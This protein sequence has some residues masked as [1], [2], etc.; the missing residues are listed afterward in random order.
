M[1]KPPSSDDYVLQTKTLLG[2]AYYTDISRCNHCNV[3]LREEASHALGCRI[4]GS[5]RTRRHTL[6]S[7][8][9]QLCLEEAGVVVK[10]EPFLFKNSREHPDLL[11]TTDKGE[12][13]IDLTITE[14]LCKS[15]RAKTAKKA[16]SASDV[17]IKSTGGIV[18]LKISSK[19]GFL[20]LSFLLLI[21]KKKMVNQ[22]IVNYLKEGKKRGFSLQ[23]L[24]QKL[25]EA[26]AVVKETARRFFYNETL[27]VKATDHDRNL[28]V[29]KSYINIKS[30]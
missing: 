4:S 9:L 8:T 18:Q 11:A 27:I 5:E 17:A 30:L 6:V 22:D 20:K 19:K 23:I 26:F 21:N 10:S 15:H 1:D 12:I 25:P 7:K 2:Q 24:K 29:S 13:A 3:E 14:A 28:S 16:M